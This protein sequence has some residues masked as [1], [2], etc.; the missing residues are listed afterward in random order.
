MPT[1]PQPDPPSV[2]TVAQLLLDYLAL[3]GVHTLFGIPGAAVAHIITELRAQRDR[4]DYVIC[5]HE[6]GAAY[7][8]EGYARVTGRPGV[9]LVTAGPG[10][11]NALTGAVNAQSSGFPLLTISG[12]VAEA[13]FGKGSLQEGMDFTVDVDAIYRAASRYS[14]F[15]ASPASFV[16]L[17]T[18]ALRDAM[19]LPRQAVHLSIPDD[20]AGQSPPAPVT[21]PASPAA[22]R[23]EPDGYSAAKVRQTLDALLAASWPLV[24]LGSGCREALRGGR[25][26]TFTAFVERFA[27]PVMTTPDAKG[28]FPE[29]HPL[30]LRTFGMAACEWPKYY[31]SPHTFDPALPARYDALLVLASSLGGFATNK[32]DPALVPAGPVI[33]VDL[34]QGAIG[35]NLPLTVGAVAEVGAFID[36]L[37]DAGQSA[38]ANGEVVARRAAFV[39]ALKAKQSPFFDPENRDSDATPIK[40]Q[41]LMRCLTEQ[42]PSGTNIFVDCANCVGWSLHYLVVDPPT[43]VHTAL[44]MAP[45]GFGVGAVVG[46]KLGAPGSPAVCVTGDA[47]FLMHGSE[48]STAAQ[49]GVG[50]VWVVLHDDDLGMVSQGQGHFFP[51]PDDPDAWKH[52]YRIGSPDVAKIAEG[53][54]ADAYSVRSVADARRIVP[55]ALARADAERKPQVIVVHI[56]RDAMPPYYPPTS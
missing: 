1:A 16:T 14:A 15:V 23:T 10:A 42:L 35:R 32:F 49:Y 46:G 55:E 41:A 12:E 19:S 30:S 54:G 28:G 44:V 31:L 21:V 13:W 29:M 34:D 6:T 48:V 20:V 11:T 50:A 26:K 5:R 37:A 27:I 33:Q 38:R 53:L 9:V 24:F 22:Y 17:L 8:A 7:I 18:Q 2:P 56:D 36:A 40:P 3:E 43:Q 51:V 45:M 25:L 47:A 52:Y 4:F 39:A